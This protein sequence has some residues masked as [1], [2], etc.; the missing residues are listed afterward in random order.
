MD[1]ST[2]IT[3][4]TS[5]FSSLKDEF[6]TFCD[7]FVSSV[8]WSDTYIKILFSFYAIWLLLVILFKKNITF[9]FC[10]LVLESVAIFGSK[11]LNN[12]AHEN[13]QHFSSQDYFDESG[14]FVTILWSVPILI[15]CCIQCLLFTFTIAVTLYKSLKEE[16]LMM[17]KEKKIEQQ[18]KQIEEEE[19]KMDSPKEEKEK[20]EEKEEEEKEEEIKT[21]SMDEKKEDEN[22]RKRK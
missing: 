11:Y 14:L 12:F 2:L 9:Q 8:T 10:A 22:L 17:L 16:K 19:K 7:V 15:I 1:F 3:N 18:K 21:I 6:H 20:E 5:E 13:W 4:V